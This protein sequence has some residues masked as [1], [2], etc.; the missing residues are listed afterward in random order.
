MKLKPL[1]TVAL[2]FAALTV[3]IPAL[4]PAAQDEGGGGAAAPAADEG[5]IAVADAAR[6]FKEMQETRDVERDMMAERERLEAVGQEKD[7]EVRKLQAQRDQLRVGAPQYEELNEKLNDAALEFRL[8]VEQTNARNERSQKRQVRA[9]FQKIEA[10]V[11]EIAQRDGYGL[12]LAKQRPELP[13]NLDRVKY[14]QIVRSLSARNVLYA[15]TKVDI[16]DE[17]I[18]L[19]DAKYKS[20][21]GGAAPA[22]GGATGPRKPA[23]QPAPAQPAAPGARQGGGGGGGQ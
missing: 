17:V 6:I 3:M 19:L 23:A 11:A 8:W 1:M 22:S 2:L 21:G 16:S 15:S 5:R 18:A 13:E 14:D 9:M 12:V 20:K 4:L 7:S 10:A